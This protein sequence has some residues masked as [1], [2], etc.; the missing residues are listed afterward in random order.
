MRQHREF[1][2]AYWSHEEDYFHVEAKTGLSWRT[3]A[4]RRGETAE[5]LTY[6]EAVYGDIWFS[7]HGGEEPYDLSRV[8]EQDLILDS[9]FPED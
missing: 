1:L 8:L 7:E 5:F 4:V 3:F 2:D 9:H 6:L